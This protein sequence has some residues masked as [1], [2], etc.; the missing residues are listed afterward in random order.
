MAGNG[1][2]RHP[3]PTTA[4][5]PYPSGIPTAQP[6]LETKCAERTADQQQQSGDQPDVTGGHTGFRELL[7]AIGTSIT[8]RHIIISPVI[9]RCRPIITLICGRNSEQN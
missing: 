8:G 5:W 9:W 3:P 7:A 1:A 6:V 2:L 4:S